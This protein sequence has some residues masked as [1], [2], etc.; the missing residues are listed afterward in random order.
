MKISILSDFHFGY[1]WNTKLEEDSYQNAQEA[2]SKCLDSDLILIAGDIFDSITPRTET[3]AKALKVLS[4]PLL[5][6]NKGAKL[7]KTINKNLPEIS[8]RTLSGIPVL[9]LHGTHERRTKEQTNTIEAL[10]QTGFLIHL[11]CNGLTFEKDGQKVAIQGMSGVPERYAKDV[12]NKWDPKPEEDCYN[13]MML[14]QSIEPYVYSPLD[15]PSLN[16]SNLPK[17]FDLI[18]DGHVHEKDLTKI[19]GTTLLLP[20]STIITQLKKEEA[21]V[22][23][24]FYQ[25]EIEKEVK[26]N[27][28]PLENN[29]K[30]FYDEIEI[31]PNVTIREQI[32]ENISKTLDQGF[33]KIPIIKMK[34]IGKETS[35]IDKELREIEKKYSDKAIIYFS[36]ELESPEMT[37]KIELLK[38]LRERKLSI[39]EMGLQILKD[40]LKDMKFSSTFDSDSAFRLLSEGETEKAFDILIGKQTT[41]T[42]LMKSEGYDN[43]D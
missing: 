1:G 31:K 4:K 11:H 41:L 34:L 8:S 14:H 29:R 17:G 42:Q 20:G 2:I 18:I 3:L 22:Q 37:R 38:N 7:I 32:E 13:I 9:A 28:V 26:I 27:F 19:D 24:G 23:K 25:V 15:P 40:N 36:K 10:E 30:F 6:E 16:L 21:D 43:K 35:V 12:L 33:K 5:T 39:E